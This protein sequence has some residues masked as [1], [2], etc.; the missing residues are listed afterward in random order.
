MEIIGRFEDS[1]GRF[2]KILA[3][4][5]CGIKKPQRGESSLLHKEVKLKDLDILQYN[6]EQ[7]NNIKNEMGQQPVRIPIDG[8]GRWEDAHIWKLKS[9]YINYTGKTQTFYHLDSDLVHMSKKMRNLHIFVMNS[10]K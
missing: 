9:F 6:Q 4:G 5:S 8:D 1:Q 3:C 2:C 7:S 10:I